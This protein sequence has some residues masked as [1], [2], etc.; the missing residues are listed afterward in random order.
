VVDYVEWVIG[1]IRVL[2]LFLFAGLLALVLHEAAYP[3]QPQSLVKL[4]LFVL[5]MV[6]VGALLTVMVGMNRDDVLSRIAGTEPGKVTWDRNFIV[7]A[8]IFG[9]VPLFTLISS[10]F[11]VV[12]S[13]LFAWIYPIARMVGGGG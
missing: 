10:E 1:Q 13:I 2:A 5:L 8:L 3:Y 6:T 4:I 12:R 11:P 7:N 9:L